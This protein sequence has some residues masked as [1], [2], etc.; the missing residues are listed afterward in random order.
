M[1]PNSRSVVNTVDTFRL[2]VFLTKG[3]PD[4]CCIDYS[5]CKKLPNCSQGLI[6]SFFISVLHLVLTYV[7]NVIV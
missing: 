5:R 6:R 4:L 2:D 7:F 3:E 1:R